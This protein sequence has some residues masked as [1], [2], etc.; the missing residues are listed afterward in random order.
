MAWVNRTTR[1]HGSGSFQTHSAA[2]HLGPGQYET[3][4]MRRVKPN[5]AAFGSSAQPERGANG[6]G[7]P[8]SIGQSIVTPGPGTYNTNNQVQ[9]E[10]PTKVQTS[11]FQSKT[12]REIAGAHIGKHNK[13]PGPGTYSKQGSFGPKKKKPPMNMVLKDTPQTNKIKWARLPSAPSIPT[14]AQSFGYEHGPYGKLVRHEPAHVGHT[15]RGDD[16]LGPG[17]YDPM[18]G[19]KSIHKP[20]ATDFSKSKV[21]RSLE[22]E[23]K[24]HADV[25]GPGQ[26][27]DPTNSMT[28]EQMRAS[29]IF[30][31]SITREKAALQADKKTPVPGPGAY[32]DSQKGFTGA[33]KPE[34]LQFFGSTSSRFDSSQREVVLSPGPG[35]YYAPPVFAA[36]LCSPAPRR[37]GKRAPFSSKKERFESGPPKE[38]YIAAPGSYNVPTAMS[39]VLNKVSSRVHSFGSTTKRFDTLNNPQELVPETNESQLERELKG[40]YDKSD[41]NARQPLSRNHMD[42]PKM[43]SA[44]VSSSTR[45][46]PLA[47]STAPSPG[48]YQIESSWTNAPGATGIFKSSTDR[49]KEPRKIVDVP[50]PGA[51]TTPTTINQKPVHMA[52]PDVFVNSEPRFRKT[53]P[54]VQVPGPGQYSTQTIENDWNRPT[55]NI[56]IATEMELAMLR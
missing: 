52:R 55:Y 3:S 13:T 51:Y 25:P 24:K 32:A 15:G 29:A 47:K 39:D 11:A 35:T 37:S 21:T 14:Q 40:P 38:E 50:G 1:G 26:Y 42:K 18:R 44:F 16:T 17:E 12:Q 9:W 33:S 56:T 28:K 10:S 54:K 7:S 5:A 46:K 6:S 22:Q 53:L 34:H 20:R 19:L 49:L 23:I 45:F 48:D 31:S 4:P 30:K 36:S 41:T 2:A 8:G 27:E 43:S